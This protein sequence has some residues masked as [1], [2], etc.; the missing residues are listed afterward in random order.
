MKK[1]LNLPTFASEAD[2]QEFW[3][4]ID[5]ANHLEKT[6]FEPV[7]FTN[8]K[9]TSQPISLRLPTYVLQRLKEKANSL[10]MPYQALIKQYIEQGLQN[11]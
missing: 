3:S 8:L 10:A 7:T 5:L 11:S 4:A 1:P 9:P 2:E 6:D